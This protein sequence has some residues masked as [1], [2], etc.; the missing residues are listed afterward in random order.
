[1]AKNVR[2]NLKK[3]EG[4]PARTI[5]IYPSV[6]ATV[7]AR[8]TRSHPEKGHPPPPPPSNNENLPGKLGGASG[9]T[10]EVLQNPGFSPTTTSV[11]KRRKARP[12]WKALDRNKRTWPGSQGIDKAPTLFWPKSQQEETKNEQA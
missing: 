4:P 2:L 10:G 1:M 3:R 12:R 5:N 7:T 8:T 9:L 6:R 11:G